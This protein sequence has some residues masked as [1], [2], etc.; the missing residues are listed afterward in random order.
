[1]RVIK[2]VKGTCCDGPG[3]RN[4]IYVAGCIHKCPGCHNPESW[5]FRA[6]REMT[7]DEVFNEVY[8]EYADVTF[9]GGDPALQWGECLEL[10]H[11][12]K[13]R[14]KNIWFYTGYE[15]QDLKERCPELLQVIDVLVDGRYDANRRDLT[16]FCGSTNQRIL[17]LKNGEIWREE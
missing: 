6:G 15:Y 2:I 12:L 16:R 17:H 13:E 14:G 3:L 10:C 1:M 11:R 5:D 4:T 8:D 9:S 7:I